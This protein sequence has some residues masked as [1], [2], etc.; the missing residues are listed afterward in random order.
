M[1]EL[2]NLRHKNILAGSH[3]YDLTPSLHHQLIYKITDSI[4][5]F[6]Y[7]NSTNHLL[8]RNLLV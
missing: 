8:T 5:I 3:A 2:I 4:Q 6:C 1:H 7:V